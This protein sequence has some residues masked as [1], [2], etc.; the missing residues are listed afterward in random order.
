MDSVSFERKFEKKMAERYYILIYYSGEITNTD[1]GV[2]FCSQNPQFI[3]VR[4]F[5]TLLELHNTI[6]RKIDQQS[7]KQIIQ[8]FDQVPITIKKGVICYRNWQLS[9]DND[10]SF[11]FDCHAQYLEI[12][13]IEL[14]IILE[15]LHFNSSGLLPI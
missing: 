9:S 11:M 6:L 13:I 4:P 5:I 12:R 1:K 15:E 7:N 10:V 3:I 2:T 8:V 14:F